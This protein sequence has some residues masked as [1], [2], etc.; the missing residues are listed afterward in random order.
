MYCVNHPTQI[1]L[2]EY[3][4]NENHYNQLNGFFQKKRDLFLEAIT[5]SRFSFVPSQA[6]YFQLLNYSNISEENDIDFAKKLTVEHKIA[7]IPLS[8]FNKD[9]LDFK[10]L[11]FCFAKTDDTLLKAADILNQL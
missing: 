1:A 9:Q 5:N 4:Q 8:V 11:R 7:S 10:A 3:L 6:T 2:A